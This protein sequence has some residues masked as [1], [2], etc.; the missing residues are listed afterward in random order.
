LTLMEKYDEREIVNV[1][2][3]EDLT[4]LELAELVR[5][6]V[7]Y[8]GKIRWD[9]SKPDGTPIKQV[10][11][12]RALMKGARVKWLDTSKTAWD[13]V[14]AN[15]VQMLDA[16]TARHFP[17]FREG[18][19]LV[20]LRSSSMIAVI[21]L[22]RES[23]VWAAQGTWH[24]QHSAKFG[25]GGKIILFDNKGISKRSRIL[26]VD[27]ETRTATSLYGE[28]ED[29]AFISTS[30]GSVSELP[31]GNLLIESSAQGRIIEVDAKGTPVW[32]FTAP[33]SYADGTQVFVTAV[34]RYR[35]GYFDDAF[36]K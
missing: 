32:D 12:F 16:E 25:R 4:I 15:S 26:A 11:L 9:H 21:D 2:V 18:Q 29:E 33:Y 10:S 1:G 27:P 36:W 34:H 31:N 23:A 22:E 30:L 8:S 17:L 3:G 7:G 6:A 35:E 5:K 28:G 13:P 20:S 19:V 24:M 14:H